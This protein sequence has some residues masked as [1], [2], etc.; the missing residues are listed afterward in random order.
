M[1]AD[2][3]AIIA[4]VAVLV[5]MEACGG[6]G[7]THAQQALD[8]VHAP[9]EQDDAEAQESLG[10]RAL[11]EQGHDLAQFN[12]GSMY[13]NGQG[14]PQDD[15]EAV[16][17]YR[18]AADQGHA[19][20]QGNLGAMLLNG[21]GVPQDHA[22]AVRWFR[23]AADQGNAFA[24]GNLGTM[25]SNGWG[26]PQDY[27]AAHMWFNLAAAQSSEEHHDTFAQARDYAA[28]RMTAEQVA[29]A[30][31]RARGTLTVLYRDAPTRTDAPEAAPARVEPPV[32]TEGA[33]LAEPIAQGPLTI[34]LRP[35]DDCWVS[36]TIDGE[37]VFSRVMR[38][39]ER[40]SYEVDDEIVLTVGDAGAFAFAINQQDGRS[41]GASGE[42]VTARITLQNYGTYVVP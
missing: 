32:R 23:A 27:V 8:G 12:L 36:L 41:L 37:S 15:A 2:Q 10:L 9:A 5:G 31:R 18:L 33:A 28:E 20:A 25:Y 4:L 17:W 14:V 38:A 39:G 40:E 24:Q 34:V 19:D 13:L 11:A 16:R 29:E 1:T 3:A 7:R 22:E 35:H 26:V 21:Q 30:R 42:V 6:S